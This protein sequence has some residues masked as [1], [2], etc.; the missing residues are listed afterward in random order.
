MTN[1]NKQR[2]LVV[3]K[4]DGVARGL[5]GE[6]VGRFERV[7]L[8]IVGFEMI[9]PDRNVG[10]KHYPESE[11]WKKKVG[12]RTLEE[13]KERDID[14][15]QVIGTDDPVKIG[16]LVKEWNVEYLTSGPVVAMVWEGPNAVKVVRKIV[17][18][19]VPANA[20]PGTIRGDFSW[21]SP[22]IA[23]EQQR[24][25]YNLI[26]ASGSVEEAR[27]EIGLWFYELEVYDYDISASGVMGLKGK[28]KS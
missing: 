17:G 3:I 18:D 28:I 20:A 12:E 22:E 7:G 4:H 1:L 11:V 23:N 9:D 16:E 25:F 15:I 24:P 10:Q 8:K 27:Y 14:P 2:T 19:T 26:H 5:I 6:I 21:D 13:Y